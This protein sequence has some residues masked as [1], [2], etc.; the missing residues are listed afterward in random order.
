MKVRLL[1]IMLLLTAFVTQ[2]N[3]QTTIERTSCSSLKV[4]FLSTSYC[5]NC[6]DCSSVFAPISLV[7]EIELFRNGNFYQRKTGTTAS[8]SSLPS[9]SYTARARYP[10]ANTPLTQC[11]RV[12]LAVMGLIGTMVS[13]SYTEPVVIGPP[14][15]DAFLIDFDGEHYNNVFCSGYISDDIYLVGNNT[16]GEDRYFI[17]I[18][19]DYGTH[20]AWNGKWFQGE[21]GV[22]ELRNEVWRVNHPSWNFW[23]GEYTV[24]IYARQN[25]CSFWD[26]QEITF[27]VV[28]DGSCRLANEE[29][30]VDV[31]V[32][33]NPTS[34]EIRLNNLSV[35]FDE[36]IPYTIHDLSG[37][38]VLSGSLLS[39]TEP[40]QVSDL[41]NGMYFVKVATEDKLITKKFMVTK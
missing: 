35:S 8:F 15:V 14:V 33:P 11:V 26:D 9:G 20:T 18:T 39:P 4:E 36:N 16:T 21:I 28:N 10:I 30:K 5:V 25:G 3:A 32:S 7:P 17:S 31:I 12:D 38:Q 27:T 1:S 13:G 37:K 2:I 24:Y 6:F 40:I 34:E 41:P 19:G 22:V 23:P 29:E